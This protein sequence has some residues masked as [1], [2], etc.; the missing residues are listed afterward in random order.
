MFAKMDCMEE[1]N[2][3]V[4]ETL[5]KADKRNSLPTFKALG[6]VIN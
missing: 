2:W 4:M 6:R 3:P 5:I 1:N